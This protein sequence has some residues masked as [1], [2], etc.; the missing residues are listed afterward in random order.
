MVSSYG[1]FYFPENPFQYT[2]NLKAHPEAEKYGTMEGQNTNTL[3]L[4]DVSKT[5]LK[6]LSVQEPNVMLMQ[7]GWIQA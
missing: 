7:T 5:N 1:R 2:W 3:K 6:A 4:T